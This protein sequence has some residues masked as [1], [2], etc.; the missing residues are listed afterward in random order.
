MEGDGIPFRG[1]ASV[2]QKEDQVMQ[3]HRFF[4][5]AAT[6]AF[7]AAAALA[8]EPAKASAT[9][10][11]M[12]KK[13]GEDGKPEY[14]TFAFN[15]VTHRDGT[16]T[17]EAELLNRTQGSQAHISIDCLAV[18]DG[19]VARMSGAVDRTTNPEWEGQR[20]WFKVV[21]NGEGKGAEPDGITLVTFFPAWDA[22]S[23]TP[24][25]WYDDPVLWPVEAGNVQVK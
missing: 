24:N 7:L 18:E 16:T 20:V 12:L 4:G 11:G 22:P 15:A 3:F 19:K 8:G 13:R 5:L 9:G 14:R 23:C 21:D 17:G 25:G 1:A 10:S 2:K 6:A